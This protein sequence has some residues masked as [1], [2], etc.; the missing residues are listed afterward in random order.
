MQ[1][2]TITPVVILAPLHF[3]REAQEYAWAHN[4]F[5]VSL[6]RIGVMQPILKKI[7]SF[8]SGFKREYN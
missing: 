3:S 7:D 2:D 1:T 8:V 5:M 6:E 4:I